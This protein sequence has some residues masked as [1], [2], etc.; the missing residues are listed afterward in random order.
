MAEFVAGNMDRL[1]SVDQ[2]GRMEKAATSFLTLLRNG[3]DLTSG[4]YSY[5]EGIYERTM[6]AMGLPAVNVHSDRKSRGLKYG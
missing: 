3:E 6:G 5:L 4:Q 1:R 2:N